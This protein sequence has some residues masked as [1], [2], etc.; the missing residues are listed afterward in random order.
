MLQIVFF[1]MLQIVRPIIFLGIHML[2]PWTVT[3]KF[4]RCYLRDALNF[5]AD[6]IYYLL[7]VNVIYVHN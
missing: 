2:N 5:L 6:V 4:L 7:L 3:S 1:P